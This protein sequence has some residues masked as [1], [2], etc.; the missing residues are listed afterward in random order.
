MK[1]KLFV[2]LTIIGL[3]S[4]LLGPG[5]A[6][7]Q[8]PPPPPTP[9]PPFPGGEGGRPAGAQQG[10]DGTWFMPEG[11]STMA[12]DHAVVPLASG[13]PDDFGYTW[14]D[15]VAFSWIDATTGTDTGMS[16]S[17]YGQKVG[18]IS[19]PFSFKFYENT[20][21]SLYIAA[22]GY[23]GFTD[24][25]SWPWQSQIPSPS[26][27]NNVI[28]PYWTPLDLESAGPTGRVYYNS[29]GSA[30]NRYF[31]VEWHDVKF[32]DE[33]YRFEVILYENGDIVFQ[34]QTMTYIGGRA[35]GASGIED[36][37]GLDGLSY[38]GF[39]QQAPSN[40]AVRFY[41]PPASA[42]L[43]IRPAYQ[44]RFSTAGTLESFQV[45]I[46][47]T[48]ELGAD[49][50]DITTASTWPVSLYAA[51]GVTPLN[52]TDGDTVVD[53][54][55]V[56]QGST[57]N[58]VVKVQTPAIANVGD[59]NSAVITAR[60][61][62]NTSKSKT[63]TLQTAVPAPFAQVYRDNADGA[64]SL[65]L[66]Q[67]NA[68]AVK[69]ATPDGYYGSDMAVAEMPDSFAYFWTKYRWTGSVSVREIEYTL[70]DRYGQTVR[71][72]SPLTYHSGATMYTYD[73]SPAVAV[74]PN[75]RI[76]VLC[77]ATAGTTSLP[78]STTISTSPS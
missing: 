18:P 14:D 65:Y 26:T 73:S 12:P 71:P 24:Y 22:S 21:T 59:D 54:G 17:S 49:T 50:Y 60:S 35:C 74:A 33:T 70:L 61:S 20:Y 11:A 62:V 8:E 66:V 5:M 29:G 36:S 57:V 15:T 31:V 10:P 72:V 2:L 37:A 52:D 45:P 25:S 53:T 76:G 44:G 63:A 9:E 3:F 32:T 68:Q 16:G 23:L 7:A 42:R 6:F 39:C 56:A 48:G 43:S 69:K 30:P 34:Y 28:A 19:P 55:S 77:I 1:R 51:D 4:V 13:G 47:N 64:M 27:P 75:G 58:V 46:R 41:R 67:P 38:V 78:C 40:K